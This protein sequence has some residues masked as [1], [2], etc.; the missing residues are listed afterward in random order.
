MLK[1]EYEV[2]LVEQHDVCS[3][4][5]GRNGGHLWPGLAD[6]FADSVENY[7]AEKT[8]ELF[9]FSMETK[10]YIEKFI[11][12]NNLQDDC[13]LDVNGSL[14]VATTP[15]E[16][17]QLEK[18]FAIMKECGV[19]NQTD[20]QLWDAENCNK[21]AK[22]SFY[23]GMFTACA[24]QLWPYKFVIHVLQRAIQLGVKLHS[25]TKITTINKHDSGRFHLHTN[26]NKSFFVDRVIHATNAWANELVPAIDNFITPIRGQ[27]IVTEPLKERYWDIGL[28]LSEGYDY[29]IQ[30]R[31]KRV[32]LGGRRLCSKTAEVGEM[33]DST[34]NEDISAALRS[35]LGETFPDVF[36]DYPVNIDYEW[37]GI[38]GFTKDNIPIVDQV[39]KDEF[40]VAGFSG[41]GMPMAFLCGRSVAEMAAHQKPQ[42]FAE[43]M[44]LTEHRK[45]KQ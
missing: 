11:T 2:I 15:S 37:T 23:G 31:D 43:L 19:L 22:G 21:K 30:R 26:N 27:V 41:H 3:G 29:M 12:D 32:V 39:N 20:I 42:H 35:L 8:K 6:S 44:L 36:K 18:D 7:G 24:G 14:Y 16:I 40:V 33:D 10:S 9:N 45:M 28:C 1:P 13:C 5:T 38:M 25:H 4:A 17:E 34:L